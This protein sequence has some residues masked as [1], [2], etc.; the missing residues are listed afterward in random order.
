[1]NVKIDVKFL[2]GD[3]FEIATED[4]NVIAYID[5]PSQ[6][7]LPKGQNPLQMFLSATGGCVGVYAKRYLKRH[8][9]EFNSLTVSV[10]ADLSK[11]SP[12]RLV[13]IKA[14]VKTDAQ[15]GDKK[16]VFE[17]FIRGCPVHNTLINTKEVSIV[18]E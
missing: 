16:E 18:L 12:L 4:S 14:G 15:L 1:M 8:N 17:K 6:D 2:E 9:I 7:Y 11:D 13:N 5:K 3:K 10:S